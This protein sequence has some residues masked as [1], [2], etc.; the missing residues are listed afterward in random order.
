MMNQM[1]MMDDP[2]QAGA[3]MAPMQQGGMLP[4]GDNPMAT[5]EGPPVEPMPG[6]MGLEQEAPEPDNNSFLNQALQS[7]NIAEKM[8]KNKK[9]KDDL[10]KI[11]E[12]VYKGWEI[13]EDSRAEWIR[14]TKEW[15]EL[16]LLLRKQRTFPWPKASN[17]KYPLVATAAMQ[18]S[19]RAYPALVPADGAIVKTKI[20][21]KFPQKELFEAASRV[22]NHM[23]FQVMYRIPNW[24]EDMD[25]LLMTMA[26]QGVCWKK[27]YYDPIA[28]VN[29]SDI[30]YPENLAIN[31]GVQTIEQAYRVTEKVMLYSNDIV[32]RINA[33]EYL[34]VDVGE[35]DVFLVDGEVKEAMIGSTPAGEVNKATQHLILIQHTFLDL[36]EDGYEEPYVVTV[37]ARTRKVLRIVARWDM[38][39]MQLDARGGVIRIQPVNYFTTFSFI[40]NPDGSIYAL[41]FGHLLGPL[42]VSINTLINQ[43]VDAGTM[44]NLS[45]GFIGKGLRIKMGENFLRPGEWKVVNATGDDLSKSVFPMPTKEPSAVLLNLMNM[46]IQ[47]GNQLAS[48]AEIF[49]GKMPGQ[50]T[51]ATTTQETVQQSMAVFT[52][53]YKRVYR[54]LWEEFKKLYRLNKL[55]PA[56]VEEERKLAG[57]K[58]LPTT[59]YD[60]PDWIIM[61]AADPTGDSA[62]MKAQKLQ[63]VG[64]MLQ[65]GTINVQSYTQRMLEMIEIPNPEELMQQPPPPP[66]DPKAQALQM[67]AE[68]DQQKA[69]SDMAAKQQEMELKKQLGQLEMQLKAMELKFKEQ[70]QA[71]K[72]QGQQMEQQMNMVS[73]ANQQQ[74][75]TQRAHAQMQTEGVKRELDLKHTERMMAQKEKQAAQQP[76]KESSKKEK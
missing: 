27:T 16:A 71:L 61:P 51:P 64:Q 26:I 35:P 40:P 56:T 14:N 12:K 38:E 10:M 48:I 43:L 63:Q 52:A 25:K 8:S 36:D 28:G 24:E 13:D 3:G 1:P 54:A 58:D 2:T 29:R 31:Y 21:Q 22:A 53:I 59:D 42:N 50:N 75:E 41:G 70:E 55:N 60:H 6:E 30:V 57:M 7:H 37:H 74:F 5:Q 33:G 73:Q 11:A 18:F 45:S 9:G 47:S 67:K 62:S 68:I 23:S 46:L 17:V 34:D 44:N 49:V 76:K 19:A 66:P 4:G 72:L 32:E 20:P 15:L 65:F 69:Q 39:G